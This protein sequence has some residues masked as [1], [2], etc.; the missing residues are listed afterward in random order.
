VHEGVS[1]LK[2]WPQARPGASE[3]GCVVLTVEGI[4]ELQ[5]QILSDMVSMASYRNR[6]AYREQAKH[7]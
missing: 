1:W 6:V 4:T 7:S 3:N 2:A 5:G